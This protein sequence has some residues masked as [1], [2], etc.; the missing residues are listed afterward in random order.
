MADET[1]T[2]EETK[3]LGETL[4]EGMR[5]I[6]G[7]ETQ[8]GAEAGETPAPAATP[9][10]TAQEQ[11]EEY[12]S[13]LDTAR[14]RG[15]NLEYADDDQ[16]F[17]ALLE[18]HRAYQQVA[19]YLPHVQNFLQHQQKFQEYLAAQARA[20]AEPAKP[21]EPLPWESP[22]SEAE[23][24]RLASEF[25][26]VDPATGQRKFLADAP[27]EARQKIEQYLGHQRAYQQK[28][29]S[30]FPGLVGAALRTDG[31][32]QVLAELLSPIVQQHNQEM[33]ARQALQQQINGIEDRHRS[34]VYRHDNG[35]VARDARGAFVLTPEGAKFKEHMS[36]AWDLGVGLKFDQQGRVFR[37][38]A[39]VEQYALEQMELRK[40][41]PS[42]KAPAAKSAEI[43]ARNKRM[44][45]RKGNVGTPGT[46][47]DE[48]P[49]YKEGQDSSEFF[50]QSYK[51][52]IADG[53]TE[54]E[55]IAAMTNG[56]E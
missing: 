46:G 6:E 10:P 26:P 17:N 9:T 19:P 8:T 5:E 16:A 31:M 47:K 25:Y 50:A 41:R 55:A 18:S 1:E 48:V 33:L 13:L 4:A 28:L 23:A 11:A 27:L 22:I 45:L 7:A 52:W 54:E 30:D 44:A 38:L 40:E 12:V 42:A 39:A 53:G 14:Q 56:Q 36:R 35:Q 29:Q 24:S 15:V 37:D 49:R 51:K 32:R 34:W 20:L 21:K 3:P 43:V 2:V